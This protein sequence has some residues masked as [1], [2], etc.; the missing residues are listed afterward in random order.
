LA[1][2]EDKTAA[3]QVLARVSGRKKV[4]FLTRWVLSEFNGVYNL[5]GNNAP[6]PSEKLEW[7][8]TGLVLNAKEIKLTRL[9]WKQK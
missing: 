4:V 6:P 5:A 1:L 8:E 2:L 3:V 7:T 9:A